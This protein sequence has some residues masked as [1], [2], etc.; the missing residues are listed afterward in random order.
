LVASYAKDSELSGGEIVDR[1]GRVLGR[2]DGIHTVTVGQRHGLGISSSVPLYVVEIDEASKRVIM[3]KK[4]ELSCRGL[5]ADRV[6]W[7]LPYDESNSAAAV[8]IRY[9]APAIPCLIKPAAGGRVEVHF[10]AGF[11]AVTPGQA[12]VFYHGAQ[13]LGGGWIE[14][15]LR[16]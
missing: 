5:V 16:E 14:R 15:A 4:E 9:R 1:S 11:P 6:N 10:E 8:Q 3:G 13:V 7:I 12:A 2:H